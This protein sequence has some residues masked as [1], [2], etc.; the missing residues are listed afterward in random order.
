MEIA[1]AEGIACGIQGERQLC[2]QKV[3]IRMGGT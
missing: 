3:G 1:S 2:E